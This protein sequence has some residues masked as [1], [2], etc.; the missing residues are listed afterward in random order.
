MLYKLLYNFKESFLYVCVICGHIC[1]SLL[2]HVYV[3][4]CAYG[5]QQPWVL[6]LSNCPPCLFLETVSYQ[7]L[8]FNGSA[9]LAGH[10]LQWSTTLCLPST[11]ITCW[12]LNSCLQV[13][14]QVLDRSILPGPTTLL[15]NE[16][17]AL[18]STLHIYPMSGS[19]AS[20]RRAWYGFSSLALCTCQE[21]SWNV[22]S[23]FR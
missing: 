5:G 13:W 11:K 10:R 3:G 14:W 8:G 16:T 7:N 20:N 21:M 19:F 2:V 1:M 12:G 9:N 4:A 22:A 6:F 15:N 17:W 23:L 18:S